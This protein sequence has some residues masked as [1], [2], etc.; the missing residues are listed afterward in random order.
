M[1]GSLFGL[2]FKEKNVNKYIQMR[3]C[4]LECRAFCDGFICG[5]GVLEMTVNSECLSQYSVYCNCLHFTI[6][7]RCLW[8]PM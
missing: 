5:R 4:L 1:Y 7:F 2:F 6:S 3:F 8:W